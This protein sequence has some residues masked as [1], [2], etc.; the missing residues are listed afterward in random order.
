MSVKVKKIKVTNL[1]AVG[2]AELDLKGCSVLVTGRNNSGK[3]TILTALPDRLR[4]EKPDAIK[5]IKHDETEG[6]TE[7]ELSDGTK[8]IWSLDTKTKAGE[9]LVIVKLDDKGEEVRGSITKDIM[10]EYFP[11]VFDVDA[12]L[13]STPAKQLK[14]LQGLAG[15]DFTRVDDEYK[16]AY[17][18]RTFANRKRDDAEALLKPINNTLPTVEDIETL[19][20][21]QKEISG[22]DEHNGKYSEAEAGLVKVKKDLIQEESELKK[23]QAL[24]V[25]SE[26]KIKEQNLR[27]KNGET[28]LAAAANKPKDE[29]HLEKITKQHDDIRVE[30]GKIKANNE[31]IQNKDKFE[32]LKAEAKEKDNQVQRIVA[33]KDSMIKT[34]KMPEGF[35]FSNEGITYNGFDFDSISQS[36]SAKYIAGLKLAKMSIGKVS[37]LHFD[38]SFLDKNSL[39]EVEKWANDND[40][41]LL[42]ERPDFEAG[43]IRY[44]LIA[45]VK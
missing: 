9:R 2:S 32:K 20:K 6:L 22:I 23:L 36:S 44:E 8:L 27:I 30:N 15:I 19:E 34:A 29:A 14:T 17:E 11:E 10:Q 16:V 37:C 31:A 3:T 39:A 38:A 26:K 18:D 12:F 1:K 28:W 13:L 33:K 21:L 41:Q 35:G 5:V 45:D 42:I 7:W 25:S 40:L 4:G 43:E 24:V